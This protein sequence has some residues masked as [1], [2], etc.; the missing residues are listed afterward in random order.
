MFAAAAANSL[1]RVAKVTSAHPTTA[2]TTSAHITPDGG[3]ARLARVAL[4][5]RPHLDRQRRPDPREGVAAQLALGGLVGEAPS[6]RGHR[7]ER[8]QAQPGGG[9]GR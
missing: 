9:G 6:E 4:F 1:S 8:G 5:V 7:R 3:E 2:S